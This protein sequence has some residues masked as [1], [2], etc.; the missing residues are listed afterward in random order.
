M[1]SWV[2]VF[3]F[4]FGP[5]L[6]LGEHDTA[7][8][9]SFRLD[10]AD[11]PRRTG[12]SA[13]VGTTTTKTISSRAC[14]RSSKRWWRR[15]PMCSTFMFTVTGTVIIIS[16]VQVPVGPDSDT[17]QSCSPPALITPF[18]VPVVAQQRKGRKFRLDT[19]F[20][21]WIVKKL[22]LW[23]SRLNLACWGIRTR[24]WLP[25]EWQEP[26]LHLDY[27]P[28]VNRGLQM[29]PLWSLI[30]RLYVNA[31][32]TLMFRILNLDCRLWRLIM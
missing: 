22:Q 7:V 28:F 12:P 13:V 20:F 5:R 32:F 15:N 25:I 8:S 24:P 9:W 31:M 16:Q 3:K 6:G 4:Y 29:W 1:S 17:C 11:S 18:F 26:K 23:R 14:Q 2:L 10:V 30:Q 27:Q 21:S 19:F